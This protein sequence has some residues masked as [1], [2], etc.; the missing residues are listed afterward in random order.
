LRAFASF[1]P[2]REPHAGE[3]HRPGDRALYAESPH[4][5][6]RIR[7]TDVDCRLAGSLEAC[8]KRLQH[9]RQ[10]H[11]RRFHEKGGKTREIFVST[12]AC[13]TGLGTRV[14]FQ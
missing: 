3:A 2:G 13:G 12:S 1:D 7:R 9:D 4:R 6:R 8:A 10:Q 11:V 14:P 5:T